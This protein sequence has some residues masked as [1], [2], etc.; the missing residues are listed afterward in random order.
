MALASQS[1]RARAWF[2]ETVE[3]AADG[4]ISV[5][6]FLAGFALLIAFLCFLL[7]FVL[8]M[9]D[10]FTIGFGANSSATELVHNVFFAC[11]AVGLV[12][13]GLAWL[14]K[15]LTKWAEGKNSAESTAGVPPSPERSGG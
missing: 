3:T 5:T 7:V 14:F 15:K 1:V 13:F 4:L 2:F 10:I 8:R 6:E 11:A 9:A 12:F